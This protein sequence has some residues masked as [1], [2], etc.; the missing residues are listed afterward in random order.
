MKAVKCHWMKVKLCRKISKFSQWVVSKLV[1]AA[2]LIWV[3]SMSIGMSM[4]MSWRE[5]NTVDLYQPI[6]QLNGSPHFLYVLKKSS[7]TSTDMILVAPGVSEAEIHYR[8]LA[9]NWNSSLPQWDVYKW[10]TLIKKCHWWRKVRMPVNIHY[11]EIRIPCHD[12]G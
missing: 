6:S 9:Q 3:K 2:V 5:R 12:S 10:I 8:C 7:I 1:L 4:S 11:K